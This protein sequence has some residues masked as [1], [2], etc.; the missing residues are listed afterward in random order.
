MKQLFLVSISIII[1]NA[2]YT[3]QVFLTQGKIE[4]ERKTNTH[5]LYLSE[6]S[7]S[8]S[9]LFKK[10]I[11]QFDITYFDL[12]FTDNKSVYRPG[13]EV[14]VKK[15]DFFEAPAVENI[16]YKDLRQQTAISQK[17]IFE[18][19]FLITDSIRQLQWKILPET[20]EIAGYNCR[21][22]L[23][24][25]CDS[26]VVVAFYTDEIVPSSGPESFS[27]L[28]GMILEIAIPRLYSTWTAVKVEG[29][30]SSDE[31]KMLAPAKGKKATDAEMIGQIKDA[32]KSWGEKYY[33]RAV[34]FSTL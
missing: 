18:S 7:D 20:R 22:A 1:F 31:K 27:G 32:I 19:Q 21:K 23:T 13:K 34:W 2:A 16:V 11:P 6:E 9:E 14:E 8:W 10:Q 26:V 15:L 30:N 12:Y 5:R 28:P 3:Q 33:H 29:L 17:Q 24:R 4:F 25:I